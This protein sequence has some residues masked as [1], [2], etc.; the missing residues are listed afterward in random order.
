MGGPTSYADCLLYSLVEDRNI[1]TGCTRK[2]EMNNTFV[3]IHLC[4]LKHLLH[5]NSNAAE[6][7]VMLITCA[8]SKE[9]ADLA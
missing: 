7:T 1:N 4:N 9:D 6:M 8:T 5:K 2:H 3:N